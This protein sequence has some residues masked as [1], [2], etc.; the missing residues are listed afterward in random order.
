M[1]PLTAEQRAKQLLLLTREVLEGI[2]GASVRNSSSAI[3]CDDPTA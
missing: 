2:A 1:C 3:E